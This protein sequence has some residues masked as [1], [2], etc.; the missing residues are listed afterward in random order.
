MQESRPI[1]PWMPPNPGSTLDHK[2]LI[3]SVLTGSVACNF[4][5]GASS[6]G[7]RER[8][9]SGEGKPETEALLP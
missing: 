5:V 4:C 3:F 6:A 9:N 7:V 2:C 1:Q 8:L